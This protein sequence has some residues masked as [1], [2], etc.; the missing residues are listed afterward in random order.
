MNF[1]Y[2]LPCFDYLYLAFPLVVC[3]GR[4]DRLTCSQSEY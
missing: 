2:K 3:P 1:L 4:T